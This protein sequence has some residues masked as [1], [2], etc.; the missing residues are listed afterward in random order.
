[1]KNN[2]IRILL[3]D[4]ERD[5]LEFIS[6]NLTKEGYEV[7]TAE[8]GK[9]AIKQAIKIQPHLILLDVM[10]PEIDGI[11]TC[12]SLKSKPELS[13]TIIA[14]LSARGEDYSQITG[15]E[16]GADDYITKPIRPKVLI[17]KVK[18]LLRRK[19]DIPTQSDKSRIYIKD[20]IIDKENLIM[21]HKGEKISIPRKEFDVL[22]LLASKK[23]KVV[24]REELYNY[25]WGEQIIV[26]ERTLDVHIR[27]L[28]KRIG[29]NNIKTIKGV[30]YMYE[31]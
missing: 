20:V 15:L 29:I 2:K 6:Y 9:E 10:M 17:S 30:G 16:A 18:S 11:D 25:L 24:R 28:R 4:D 8:N 21:I 23:N 19:I 7:Y 22:Y 3:V 5:I 1:M 14:F 27:R 26:G 13:E 31:A 12:I